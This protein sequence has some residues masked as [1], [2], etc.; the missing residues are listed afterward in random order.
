MTW[1]GGGSKEKTTKCDMGGGLTNGPFWSGILFAWPLR[2]FLRVSVDVLVVMP[3]S[4]VY[5]YRCLLLKFGSLV[6]KNGRFL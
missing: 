2:T 4:V 1:G 6:H 3:G 5:T